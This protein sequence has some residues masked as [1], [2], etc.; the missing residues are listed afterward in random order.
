MVH[1]VAGRHCR[2][3]TVSNVTQQPWLAVRATRHGASRT[4]R[5]AAFAPHAQHFQDSAQLS[6]PITWRRSPARREVSAGQRAH[7]ARPAPQRGLTDIDAQR[8][9]QTCWVI[10]HTFAMMPERCRCLS[11]RTTAQHCMQIINTRLFLFESQA[12]HPCSGRM[13]AQ[14]GAQCTQC[15]QRGTHPVGASHRLLDPRRSVD[16]G[17]GRPHH[18]RQGL[19]RVAVNSLVVYATHGLMDHVFWHG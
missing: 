10:H 8:V 12:E 16:T 3:A 17:L 2:S 14:R 19:E 6:R 5:R 18:I 15:R 4:E 1:A 11:A 13:D 7:G 9:H